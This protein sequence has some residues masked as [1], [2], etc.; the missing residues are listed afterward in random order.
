MPG[1]I[2]SGFL[3]KGHCFRCLFTDVEEAENN[4]VAIARAKCCI[5]RRHRENECNAVIVFWKTQ[6]ELK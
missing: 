5:R 2:R 3:V 4:P 6:H 1:G